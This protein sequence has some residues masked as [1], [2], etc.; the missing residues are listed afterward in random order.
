MTK[1]D[2]KVDQKKMCEIQIECDKCGNSQTYSPR[3]DNKIPKRPKTL[4]SKCESW[5]YIDKKRLENAIDQKPIKKNDQLTKKD[6]GNGAKAGSGSAKKLTRNE[7]EQVD[8]TNGM[9]KEL[10]LFGRTIP[11]GK[12][13][14]IINFILENKA[15]LIDA[16]D[17]ALKAYKSYEY[18]KIKRQKNRWQREKQFL[19]E[20]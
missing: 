17:T 16:L 12:K 13:Q 11:L 5:I 10:E 1:T 7:K 2:Q 8:F 20:L 19:E 9:L 6:P 3:N 14:E 18:D 15:D 4:C